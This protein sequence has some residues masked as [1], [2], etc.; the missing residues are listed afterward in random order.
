MTANMHSFTGNSTAVF[1]SSPKRTGLTVSLHF[2][3]S[4]YWGRVASHCWMNRY[5]HRASLLLWMHAYF[6]A[7][8]VQSKKYAM[9]FCALNWTEISI[10]SHWGQWNLI[11]YLWKSFCDAMFGLQCWKLCACL[12]KQTSLE[13]EE[14]KRECMNDGVGQYDRVHHASF[15]TEDLLCQPVRARERREI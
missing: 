6:L 8:G 5:R 7:L 14:S 1:H 4:R 15:S 11:E 13:E 10:F 12:W 3:M 9:H 2:S